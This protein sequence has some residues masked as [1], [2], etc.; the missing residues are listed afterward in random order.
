REALR[1]HRRE[2]REDRRFARRMAA[3]ERA[4]E[5]ARERDF[6]RL[7]RQGR[8]YTSRFP[9]YGYHDCPRWLAPVGSLCVRPAELRYERGDRYRLSHAPDYNIPYRYRDYYRDWD[10]A[11]YR[12]S[13]GYIY[14]I[15][16][17]TAIVQAAIPL[18]GGGF[19]VGQPLPSGYSAYNVPYAYRPYYADG[20]DYSYRYGDGAIY[21]VDP[22]D[23]IILGVAALLTGDEFIVG[24]PMPAGYA[25]YN[26]PYGYR[27][28]YYDTPDTLYRYNDNRIYKVDPETMI[29]MGV[30]DLLV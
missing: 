6:L 18:L 7:E 17:V 15:D 8:V 9:A 2:L 1:E 14:R 30:I 19:S 24:E 4:R 11:N 23:N 22:K 29:V 12:Y 20:G 28:R 3:V 26:V 25:A 16:P 10:E 27:D 13:G 5:R 21:R